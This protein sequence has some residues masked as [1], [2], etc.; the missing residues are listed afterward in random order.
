AEQESSVELRASAEVGS[1]SLRIADLASGFQVVRSQGLGYH[2]VCHDALTP[3][4]RALS[5]KKSFLREL[6]TRYERQ[7]LESVI[8]PPP[9]L[10]A[11]ADSHADMIFDEIPQPGR[12]VIE[13]P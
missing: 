6:R 11:F 7:A 1:A 9:D 3:L 10:I 8:P 5:I 12:I 2:L 4:S 13:E